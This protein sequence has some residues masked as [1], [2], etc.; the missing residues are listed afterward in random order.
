MGIV[1]LAVDE[2]SQLGCAIFAVFFVDGVDVSDADGVQ[3]GRRRE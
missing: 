1:V 3:M 2:G